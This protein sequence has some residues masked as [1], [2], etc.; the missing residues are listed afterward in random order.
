MHTYERLLTKF[1]F[2]RS[3]VIELT[4]IFAHSK[5]PIQYDFFSKGLS[6]NFVVQI[7]WFRCPVGSISFSYSANQS[8]ISCNLYVAC[9]RV[10]SL[11][12]SLLNPS[13]PMKIKIY[14][15]IHKLRFGYFFHR[16]TFLRLT[17]RRY[18]V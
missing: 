14:S 8:V 13:L 3:S 2:S 11:K 6:K 7:V 5:F 9:G 12:K 18:L 10:K 17:L 16:C 1:L 4:S 15:P